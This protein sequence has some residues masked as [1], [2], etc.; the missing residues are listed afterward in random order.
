M[1][2]HVLHLRSIGNNDWATLLFV[3]S[4]GTIASLNPFLKTDLVILQI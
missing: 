2:E 3:L 1:T 4:F